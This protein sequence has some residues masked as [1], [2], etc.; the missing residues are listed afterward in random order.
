MFRSVSSLSIDWK[1]LRTHYLR[2][3]CAA[4]QRKG[5]TAENCIQGC[6]A[7]RR[8]RLICG[9]G[10]PCINC[11]NTNQECVNIGEVPASS[12]NTAREEAFS[13][14][15]IRRVRIKLACLAC[16]RFGLSVKFLSEFKLMKIARRDNKKCDERR[17]CARCLSRKEECINLV[18]T[19]TIVKKRCQ[20]CRVH[21]R[22][23]TRFSSA[24]SSIMAPESILCSA[25]TEGHASGV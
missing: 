21:N 3:I 25:R 6:R 8:A 20:G 9:G 24:Y 15:Q 12:R 2:P 1:T 10:K 19:E 14:R 22:K 23:V 16:R 13:T 4:C 17:P 7:C 11:L 5:L 18:P